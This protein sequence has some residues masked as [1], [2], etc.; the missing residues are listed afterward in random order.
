MTGYNGQTQVTFDNA[1]NGN[2]NQAQMDVLGQSGYNGSAMGSGET[3]AANPAGVQANMTPVNGTPVNGVPVGTV[4]GGNSY[5][6]SGT[7]ASQQ[8]VAAASPE[9]QVLTK[10][11]NV[12]SVSDTQKNVNEPGLDKLQQTVNNFQSQSGQSES[13]LR[14]IPSIKVINKMT[15]EELKVLKN[16]L[17]NFVLKEAEVK[18]DINDI[19]IFA[20]AFVGK[21]KTLPMLINKFYP[22]FVGSDIKITYNTIL[23]YSDIKDS[24]INTLTNLKSTVKN[25]LDS[26]MNLINQSSDWISIILSKNLSD[27]GLDSTTQLGSLTIGKF[28]AITA[29]CASIVY[30]MIKLFKSGFN[31]Q[32]VYSECVKYFDTLYKRSLSTYKENVEDKLEEYMKKDVPTNILT[33]HSVITKCVPL[34]SALL[35]SSGYDENNMITLPPNILILSTVC[36][37]MVIFYDN[38]LGKKFKAMVKKGETISN[39]LKMKMDVTS[40]KDVFSKLNNL[41]SMLRLESKR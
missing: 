25:S 3:F 19:G 8:Q 17:Q 15:R 26:T 37:A 12:A 20:K 40:S 24:S 16:H 38:L 34:A 11:P 18:N 5:T 32:E 13:Y 6:Q 27:L 29:L 36:S 35:F 31:N 30:I 2:I 41:N 22:E 1:K 33:L 7:G 9:T 39:N 28:L 4:S 23:K 21:W 14:Y 10:D